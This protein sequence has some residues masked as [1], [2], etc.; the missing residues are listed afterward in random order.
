VH[1]DEFRSVLEAALIEERTRGLSRRL[2]EAQEKGWS[3]I[4]LELHDDISQQAALLAIDLQRAIG[5]ARGRPKGTKRFVRDAL[6]KAK[7]LSRSAHDLS[8]QL[9]PSALR[10]L[11]LVPAL[12]Q[13]QRDL[14]RAGPTIT[15][16]AD[17]VMPTLPDDIALCLFRVAQ[18]AMHNAIKHSGA[19]YIR[20]GVSSK[21][22][23]VTLTVSDDG[24]GF[25]VAAATGKGLGLLSMNER[26]RAVGGALRVVS[27][28]NKGTRLEVS[29]P[30]SFDTHQE[31]SPLDDPTDAVGPTLRSANA[32]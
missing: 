15:V 23:R 26:V 7:T 6:L 4:A 20:V 31:S 5:S 14:S 9:H 28:Q 32:G 30:I 11:G 19:R 1:S 3:R 22:D 27:Q 2:L 29:V 18:E 13:L 25:N 16:A 8:H 21:N 12:A 17:H 24:C 10:L